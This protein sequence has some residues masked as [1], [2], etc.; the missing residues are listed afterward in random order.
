[1]P[2]N[3]KRKK[4]T[5]LPKVM[6]NGKTPHHT[7]ASH[8]SKQKTAEAW[9][10][11]KNDPASVERAAAPQE[12][13]EYLEQVDDIRKGHPEVTDDQADL[14][15]VILYKGGS[16]KSAA[17]AIGKND[18]WAYATLR[19]PKV[20]AYRDAVV[21]NVLGWNAASSLSRVAQI[22]QSA[23]SEKVKLEANQDLMDRAGLRKEGGP[24]MA[25]QINI[26]LD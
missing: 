5:P 9:Q 4:K 16:V 18:Q 6:E 20:I 26:D 22:A 25:V 14:V 23:K 11:L 24:S 13:V 8:K 1:M 19:K 12:L 10:R 2:S 21:E 15:H 3:P 17:D 7:P